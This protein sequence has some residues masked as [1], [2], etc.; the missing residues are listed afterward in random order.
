MNFNIEEFKEDLEQ[1]GVEQTKTKY[2]ISRKKLHS[3]CEMFEIEIPKQGC[4][5]TPITQEEIDYIINYNQMAH[6]GYHTM[7]SIAKRDPS[8]PKTL[9]HGVVT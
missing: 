5:K 7:A 9:Q 4:R 2:R 6:V 1:M 8:A 3:I